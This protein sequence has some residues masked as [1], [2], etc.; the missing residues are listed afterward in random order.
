ML[1]NPSR[2]R[3]ARLRLASGALAALSA[4]LLAV[5]AAQAAPTRLAGTDAVGTHVSSA[6]PGAAE[7]YR[8][9]ATATGD[10]TSISVNLDGSSSATA[11]EVG[12]YSDENGQ[13]TTLL[14][15]GRTTAPVAGWNQVTVPTARLEANAKYWIAVL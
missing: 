10:A 12:L 15:S 8:T 4:C 14:S 9:T 1:M 11:L 7:V 6:A 2:A 5:P 3:S 13:P